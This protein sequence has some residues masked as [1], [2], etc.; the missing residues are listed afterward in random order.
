MNFDNFDRD[1]KSTIF[2]IIFIFYAFG[3][4]RGEGRER[5]ERR[6]Y[7]DKVVDNKRM[8]KNLN[9]V[10]F[11][12]IVFFWHGRAG[13]GREG[14]GTAGRGCWQGRLNNYFI[15][16]TLYQPNTHCFTFS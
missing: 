12:I 6:E 4:E 1:S 15:C 11:I 9:P 5:R 7:A 14:E 16:D 13:H 2:F 10:S 8:T 3:G